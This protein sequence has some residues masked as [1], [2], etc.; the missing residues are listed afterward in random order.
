[1]LASMLDPHLLR[2]ER[3]R[4]LRASEYMRLVEAGV[5]EDERVELLGGVLVAMSPQGP[6]H[7]DIVRYLVER[8]VLALRGR[9]WVRP[10]SGLRVADDS[11]PEPDVAVVPKG[12][13]GVQASWANLVIE[14]S[15][16]SLR[17][18]RLV[19]TGYYAACGIREY[20]IID[21]KHGHVE[22]FTD[23]AAR[24]RRYRGHTV[25]GRGD[26]LR[27]TMLD[28]VAIAVKDVLPP[29]PRRRSPR[30]RRSKH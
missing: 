20:W 22:V 2:P 7:A 15:E 8:L 27:P 26:T 3:V 28:G 4:P 10:H 19:K 17:K 6:W 29:A 12:R 14:V 11:V 1:M 16:S 18:D 9:A 5:F 13:R 24:R 30:P 21:L 25:L 23:P